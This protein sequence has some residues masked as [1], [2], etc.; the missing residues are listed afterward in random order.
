MKIKLLVFFC[1]QD[2]IC[3]CNI[4]VRPLSIFAGVL[5]PTQENFTAIKS[6][7][8]YLNN[9]NTDNDFTKLLNIYHIYIKFKFSTKK[10]TENIVET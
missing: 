6:K 4:S 5:H 8:K 7:M 2:T 10:W 1:K 9:G 3:P